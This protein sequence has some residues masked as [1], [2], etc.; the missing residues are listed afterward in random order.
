VLFSRCIHER[1]DG[2]EKLLIRSTVI[3]GR[4]YSERVSEKDMKKRNDDDSTRG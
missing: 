1:R 2:K 4:I 3:I